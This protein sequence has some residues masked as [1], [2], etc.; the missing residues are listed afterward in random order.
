MPSRRDCIDDIVGKTGRARHEVEDELDELLNRA[1]GDSRGGSMRDKIGRAATEMLERRAERIAVWRRAERMDAI[2]SIDRRRAQEAAPTARLGMEADSVGVNRDFAGARDSAEKTRGA[3]REKYKGGFHNDLEREGLVE[4]WASGVH[5]ADITDELFELNQK[6]GGFQNITKNPQAR[7]MAEIYQ[8]H[9]KAAVSEFN[10]EGGWIKDL[11]GYVTKTTHDPDDIR[12]AGREV[13]VDKT[14]KTN[15][16]IARSFGTKDVAVARKILGEM[17]APMKNGQHFEFTSSTDPF[18][19]SVAGK[20][21]AHRELHWNT[22]ADW[23][24]YNKVFGLTSPTETMNNALDGLASG[25]ALMRKWGTKP[26]E[27]FESDLQYHYNRLAKAD[28][29]QHAELKAWEPFLRN[30]YNALDGSANKPAN[31]MWSNLASGWMS[32]QR[33]AKLLRAPFTHGASLPIKALAL[34]RAGVGFVES[35]RRT[36][37]GIFRGAKGS[38]EREVANIML[39]G[40]DAELNYRLSR[41][42][43]ADSTP[44]R[45]AK[46][47]NLTHKLSGLTSITENSRRDSEVAMAA[48]FATLRGVDY[49]KL[50]EYEQRIFRQY[51]IGPAEWDTI[52]K[53]EWSKFGDRSYL[54]PNVMDK[55]TDDDA[56]S[57]LSAKGK[58]ASRDLPADATNIAKAREDLT[59][60]LHGMYW[61]QARYGIFEPGAKVRAFAYQGATQG[62]PNLA[63]ALHLLYQ[64]RTWPME[65]FARPLARELYGGYGKLGA[66]AGIS[67]LIVGGAIYGSFFEMLREFV[68]GQDPIDRLVAHPIKYL[69]R[70]M[71]RSGAGTMAGDYLF[72]EFDRHGLSLWASLLGPT[73]GQLENVNDIKNKI[74]EGFVTGSW[75]P[76]ANAILHQVKSNLPLVDMWWTFKAFDYLIFNQI[77][78][79]LNPGYLRRMEHTMQEKQGIKFMVSPQAVHDKVTGR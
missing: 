15:L 40:A 23:R 56:R 73:F 60:R 77:Q 71:L 8:K 72:G 4:L 55:L 33:M 13:W 67:Q 75:K 11:D 69:V 39:A 18:F 54:T 31:K 37:T 27:G 29:D 66:I 74:A 48:H 58:L 70:G 43:V 59:D 57:Y 51:R 63:V 26:R 41:Y 25:T 9:L 76:V 38:A 46:L 30:A 6:R 65:T 62:A 2:K 78:E 50:P 28:D 32:V 14:L 44:G 45:L 12:V 36:F 49:A 1:D 7:R 42:D 24:A 35:Y 21:S 64:F 53:V 20:G 3:L 17:W 34:Q 47:D 5:E 68:Q 61:D 19:L 52:N 79:A 10:A 22:A 16:N